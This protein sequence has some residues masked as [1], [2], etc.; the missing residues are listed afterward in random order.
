GVQ[1][2]EVEDGLL[3]RGLQPMVARD[4]GVVLVGLA[5]AALPLVPL[6]AG[7]AEPE[8]EGEH[9]DAGLAGPAVGEVHDRVAG[10]V[11]NTGAFQGSASAFLS[12]TGSS[13]SSARTSFLRCSWSWRAAIW[14]SLASVSA[15]RR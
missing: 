10:L 1:G 15:L 14:R 7:Q 13:S 8:Q 4:P 5:V 2:L 6:A 3:L 12:W 11:G 9:G